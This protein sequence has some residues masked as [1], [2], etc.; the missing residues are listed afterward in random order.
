MNT[1]EII[2]AL[3]HSANDS[4]RVQAQTVCMRAMMGAIT[5]KQSALRQAALDILS[6]MF[7]ENPLLAKE[8]E[9]AVSQAQQSRATIDS[10][11]V[12]LF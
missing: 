8:A 7:V 9:R 6:R 1:P 2:A 3:L 11:Q 10:R 4:L 12:H 5:S